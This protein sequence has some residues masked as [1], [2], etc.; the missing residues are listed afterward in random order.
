MALLVLALF[1]AGCGQTRPLGEPGGLPV[2]FTVQ[3][4]TGYLE[5]MSHQV[6]RMGPVFMDPDPWYAADRSSRFR[7]YGRGA[8]MYHRP[9]FADPF[10]AEPGF[11]D[12]ILAGGDAPME[13]GVFRTVLSGGENRFEVLIRPGHAVTLTVLARGDRDGWEAIGHFTAADRPGQRV[14]IT[15][16]SVGPTMSVIPPALTAEADA[17]PTGPTAP[18]A[19]RPVTP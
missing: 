2:A 17:A 8:G 3:L 9:M 19:A 14:D 10:W 6:A 11:T 12:L 13:T 18:D 4:D 15:L 1:A 5:G 7:Y 16:S